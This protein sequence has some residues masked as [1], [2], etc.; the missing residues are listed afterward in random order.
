MK[1]TKTFAI[2]TL[3]AGSLFAASLA[4]QAEDAPKTPPAGGAAGAH[5]RPGGGAEMLKELGL[6]PEQETKVKAAREEMM[7]AMKALAPEERRTKGKEIR[8]A[9]TAKLKTI[10]TPEQFEKW[11]KQ[12]EKNRP[13]GGKPGAGGGD[14]PKAPPV[15]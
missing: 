10:L 1:M 15:Q 7:T 13:Q 12:M 14:K 2:A 11:Q 5:A 6:T 4:L 9:F 8:E 3:V